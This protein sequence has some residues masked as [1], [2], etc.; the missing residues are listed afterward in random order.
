MAARA[1]LALTLIAVVVLLATLAPRVRTSRRQAAERRTWQW[2]AQDTCSMATAIHDQLDARLTSPGGPEGE[3]D[4]K[5]QGLSEEGEGEAEDRGSALALAQRRWEETEHLL[6]Q[7]SAKLFSL[8]P[9][10]PDV[11]ASRALSDL[12]IALVSLRSAFQIQQ[13]IW[14]VSPAAAP[15]PEAT[16][17]RLADFHSA[18][19][20]LHA[21]I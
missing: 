21:A 10:A 20:A 13:G 18:T 12:Q 17:A 8:F 1:L 16:R 7:F 4:G 19:R 14:M 5:D 15:P 3:D 11:F 9:E 2:R 6:D